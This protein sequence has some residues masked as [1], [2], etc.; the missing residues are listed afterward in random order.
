MVFQQ[1]PLRY[2]GVLDGSNSATVFAS[3]TGTR[4]VLTGGFIA[5]QNASG[6]SCFQL[7]ETYDSASSVFFNWDASITS[8]SFSFNLGPHGI[9]AD[10]TT[11]TPSGLKIAIDVSCTGTGSYSCIFTGYRTGGG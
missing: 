10:Q 5:F 4:W 3:A 2:Y 11:T 9:Q 7:I 6:L 1:A 8:N